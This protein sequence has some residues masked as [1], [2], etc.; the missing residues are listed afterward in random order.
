[1]LIISNC[2]LISILSAYETDNMVTL[3][4]ALN[5]ICP[6]IIDLMVTHDAAVYKVPL[7]NANICQL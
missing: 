6:K 3:I 1:M 2:P 4:G 5:L 7:R